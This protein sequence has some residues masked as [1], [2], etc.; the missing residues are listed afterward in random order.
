MLPLALPN[1]EPVPI[2]SLTPNPKNARVHSKKQISQIAASIERF[3]FLVPIVVDEQRMIAAGH[4][5]FEA[6][7]KL[8]LTHVPVVR[9]AFMTEADRR[10]FALAENRIAQLS[11][12]DENILARELQELFDGGLDIDITGFSASDLDL[13]ISVKQDKSA[14]R[15]ELPIPSDAAISRLGD[16]WHIGQHRLICGDSTKVETYELLLG[17]ARAAMIFSDPPYN[18]RIDRNVSGLGKIKHCEFLQASG[19]MS[20]AEFTTFLRSVFRALVR[21]S[22][23]GSIHFQCMDWRH[24]R[25]ILDAADGVY[26]EL[27][28]LIVWKKSNAGMGAF[29]RSAHELIF[30]F[31]AGKGRNVNNFGLGEKGRYRSNVWEYA[32]ANTFRKGRKEDLEAHPTVKPLALVMDALLDCSN[33][34]DLILDPFSGSGTTLIAAHKTGRIGAAIEL[35]P[36]FVDTSLRRLVAASGLVAVHEDGRTFEE[37]SADRAAEEGHHD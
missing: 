37:V 8:R 6:A 32:G 30:A 25:E 20:Q 28:N 21:F 13:G 34:G 10:A 1:V 16:I 4:G 36:V 5:R 19:E 29:Y 33:R 27:K 17:T 35:D 26:D 7:K 23:R 24:Q 3:G 12:W 18:V 22:K 15:V 31:K 2:A 11:S 9:A 14:E